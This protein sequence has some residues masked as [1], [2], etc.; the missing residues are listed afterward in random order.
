MTNPLTYVFIYVCIHIYVMIWNISICL[1]SWYPN[2]SNYLSIYLSVCLS[3]NLPIYPSIHLSIYPSIHPSI[4]LS[5]YPSI[6]LSICI[7]N[8]NKNIIGHHLL[9]FLFPVWLTAPADLAPLPKRGPGASQGK[10][11]QRMTAPRILP[12]MKN[13]VMS[14]FW[15]VVKWP[16]LWVYEHVTNHSD[17]ENV[18]IMRMSKLTTTRMLINQHQNTI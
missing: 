10:M 6:Y 15:V 1:L 5:F 17:S 7:T 18:V 9:R 4:H 2:L 3:V 14:T 8:V 11:P 16:C 13:T 12:E